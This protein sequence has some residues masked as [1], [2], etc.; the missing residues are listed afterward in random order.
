MTLTLRSLSIPLA[1]LT[2]LFLGP[3]LACAGSG[4]DFLS[5]IDMKRVYFSGYLGLSLFP[6]TNYTESVTPV[7]GVVELKN[8]NLMAGALGLRLSPEIDVEVELSYRKPDLVSITPDGGPVSDMG[9]EIRTTAAM[10]NGY[11]N[12]DPLWNVQPFLTGGAGIAF[13]SGEFD[14]TAGVTVDSSDSDMGFA[15]QIGGG[16]KY[17]IRKELKFTTSYRYFGTTEM[18]FGTSRIDYGAHEFRLG[19]EYDFAPE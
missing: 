19:V 16:V 3:G 13:Q 7:T 8:A 14:D 12:F 2:A 5:K 11:Y 4:P 1:F 18:D 6:D 9:G 15:Y 17:K 10:I